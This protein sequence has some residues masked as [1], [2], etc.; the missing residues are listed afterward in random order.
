[1]SPNDLRAPPNARRKP[2]CI[3][4]ISKFRMNRV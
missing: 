4:G 3:N 1:V 2:A